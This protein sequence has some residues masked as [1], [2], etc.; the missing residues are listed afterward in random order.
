MVGGLTLCASVPLLLRVLLVIVHD[1]K[2][3]WPL[4]ATSINVVSAYWQKRSR[5]TSSR[6]SREIV[7]SCLD[8]TL[9]PTPIKLQVL[10][11]VQILQEHS[12]LCAKTPVQRKDTVES[13]HSAFSSS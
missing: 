8:Y 2:V 1:Q 13:K 3:V 5:T 12:M 7:V 6:D 11:S 10:P 9:R 4:F